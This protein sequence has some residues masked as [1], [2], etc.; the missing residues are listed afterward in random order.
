MT[1][2]V[3]KIHRRVGATSPKLVV[4]VEVSRWSFDVTEGPDTHEISDDEHLFVDV[5]LKG[6][7]RIRVWC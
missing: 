4:R 1:V 7:R 2:S 6:R 3:V 5:G